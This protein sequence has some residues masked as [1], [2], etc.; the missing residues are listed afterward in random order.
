M[1]LIYVRLHHKGKISTY[2]VYRCSACSKE[3][4]R[5]VAAAARL[6]SCGCQQGRRK[7]QRGFLPV[8]TRVT[9]GGET[10]TLS[11]WLAVLGIRKTQF[12][13]KY[14]EGHRIEYIF[15]R[16]A[17]RGGAAPASSNSERGS[18]GGDI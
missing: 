8:Q 18:V 6:G 1:S 14:R 4:V 10:R 11:E 2:S 5:T 9:Y 13:R 7:Q 3:I 16:Y 15:E 12:D 17:E